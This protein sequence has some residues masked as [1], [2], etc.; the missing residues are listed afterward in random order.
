MRNRIV[1]RLLLAVMMALI[2]ALS[3]LADESKP[4]EDSSPN[5]G[6]PDQV[7]NQIDDDAE[8]KNPLLE[9]GFMH[10]YRQWKADL[11]TRSGLSFGGDYSAVFLNASAGIT[12]DRSSGGMLRLYGSWQILGRGTKNNGA[13]IVKVENRHKYGTIAPSDLG[14]AVGYIGFPQPAFNDAGWWLGNLYWRQRMAGGRLVMVAGWVDASDYIDVYGLVSPW[15]HF[16]NLAFSTGGAAMPVPN[17]ALGLAGAAMITDEIYAIAGLADSNTDPGNLSD[18][19]QSF[20][21]V[22]ELFKHIE[23]GWTSSQGNIYVD[24]VHVTY[25]HADERV[26][27]MTPSGWGLNFSASKFINDKFDPFL[28]VS[29][30]KDGGTLL[31][32]SVSAGVGY[33]PVSGGHLLGVGAHWGKPNASSFGS[34]LKDQYVL[35]AFYRL[36]LATDLQVTPDVQ[37]LINPAQN[38]DESSIWVLGVRGRISF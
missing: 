33:L 24:N 3:A 22:A 23:V 27:A 6:G 19:F 13:I 37:L 7:D 11:K 14:F 16:M 12:E 30:A 36:Q 17:P 2:T 1:V 35:E 10:S 15:L 29:Y 5:F 9:F 21:D 18:E 26:A 32:G 25:W 38:P 8:V 28:R 20:F 4:D 31:E 34:G